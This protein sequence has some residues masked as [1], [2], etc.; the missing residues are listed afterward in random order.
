MLERI[1]ISRY[2][3]DVAWINT[4]KD[5]WYIEKI[6]IFNKGQNNISFNDT[7]IKIFNV[8]NRGREGGTYLDY[9]ID[10]YGNFPEIVNPV[11]PTC[12][13]LSF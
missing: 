11:R 12:Q 13:S 5:N 10:N 3:E 1:V 4:I 9:I 2:N 6:I 8:P 7:K